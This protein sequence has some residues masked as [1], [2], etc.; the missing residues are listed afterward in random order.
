MMATRL[1]V[2]TTESTPTTWATDTAGGATLTDLLATWQSWSHDNVNR[3][4]GLPLVAGAAGPLDA[5]KAGAE[6]AR[7]LTGW[8]W[9]AMRDAREQGRS[10]ADI[11]AALGVTREGARQIYLEAIRRQE[12]HVPDHHPTAAARA[13][14][15]AGAEES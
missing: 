15:V 6:L 4:A 10:W 9:Q 12:Q 1:A 8:R 11:G 14:A 3:R 5:L 13:V 7:L 2:M